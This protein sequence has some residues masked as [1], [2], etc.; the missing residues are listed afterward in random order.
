MSPPYFLIS[1]LT[2]PCVT[3]LGVQRTPVLANNLKVLFPRRSGFEAGHGRK[4]Q[5]PLAL[6]EVIGRQLDNVEEPVD[7]VP[8]AD[9]YS[10]LSAVRGSTG[11]RRGRAY[12]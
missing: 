5:L 8:P 11:G 6:P 2:N 3:N 12:R 7:E 1:S 9:P 4:V 10:L